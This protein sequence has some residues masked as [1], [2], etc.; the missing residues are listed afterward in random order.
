MAKAVFRPGEVAL[1][2]EK[3]FLAPPHE[4]PELSHLAP[5]EEAPEEIREVEEYTG[6]TADELRREAEEFKA[7]WEIRREE[8]IRAA[9]DEAEAILMDARE[10]ARREMERKAAEGQ[11]EKRRAGEDAE[12]IIAAAREKAAAMDADAQAAIEQE[13]KA[14]EA[15]G[16]E[17]GRTAGFEEGWAEVDR[18]IQRTRTALER[19]QDKRMEILETT[20]Q[21]LIDLVLLIS[22][23]VIKVLSENQR[24]VVISNVVHA[25]RKLKGRGTVIIRVNLVDVKLT[26]EHTQRFIQLLEGGSSI[27]V[28]EDST[29]DPGGCII[30]TDFGEIDARISSQLAEL[31]SKILELSPIK[32]KV[33]PSSKGA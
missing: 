26:T 33:K 16:V 21:Q 29:V 24:N 4:F 14:A 25:L 9:K 1:I 27:Q 30:E 18:L 12:E 2:D 13:R 8:M 19:A 28:L 5:V 6:P 17:A 11:E 23:K 31:E 22:R 32:G 15:Q 7:Q 20:E 3:V 10:A